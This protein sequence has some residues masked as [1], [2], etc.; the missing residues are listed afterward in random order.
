MSDA[1]QY[2]LLVATHF[3]L[4]IVSKHKCVFCIFLFPGHTFSARALG[5]FFVYSVNCLKESVALTK[6]C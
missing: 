6:S 3:C 1:E 4:L 2:V 5:Y